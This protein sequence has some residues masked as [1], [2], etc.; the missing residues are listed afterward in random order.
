MY[1]VHNLFLGVLCC[2]IDNYDNTGSTEIDYIEELQN[3]TLAETR[4]YFVTPAQAQDNAPS[5]HIHE[6]RSSSLDTLHGLI[7]FLVF[8]FR[9]KFPFL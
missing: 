7:S 9:E 5:L 8:V 4:L 1:L 2:H 6:L 3:I